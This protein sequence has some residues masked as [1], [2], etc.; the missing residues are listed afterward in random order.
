MQ[1]IDINAKL[2]KVIRHKNKYVGPHWEADTGKKK[3]KME[4][5]INIHGEKVRKIGKNRYTNGRRQ[6]KKKGHEGTEKDKLV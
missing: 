2:N 3:R 4:K 5:N 1:G 6:R